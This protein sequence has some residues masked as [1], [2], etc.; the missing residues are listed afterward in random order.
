MNKR[1]AALFVA[2]MA[3]LAGCGGPSTPPIGPIKTTPVEEPAGGFKIAVPEGW[4][5]D[6][7]PMS[8][9]RRRWFAAR[10]KPANV[11][12]PVEALMVHVMAPGCPAA[13]VGSHFGG[14]EFASESDPKEFSIVGSAP[15]TV[16]THAAFRIEGKYKS[17]RYGDIFEASSYVETAEGSG[18]FVTS[19]GAAR[20]DAVVRA[21]LD[22]ALAGLE[23]VKRVVRA[24]AAQPRTGG[25]EIGFPEGFDE[26]FGA[27]AFGTAAYAIGPA[28]VQGRQETVS[29]LVAPPTSSGE[30][31]LAAMISDATKGYKQGDKRKLSIAG[32]PAEGVS[33][34]PPEKSPRYEMASAP[35]RLGDTHAMLL[36]HAAMVPPGRAL[37]ILSSTAATIKFKAVPAPELK[38]VRF[39]DGGNRETRAPEGWKTTADQPVFMAILDEA[40]KIPEG[41]GPPSRQAAVLEVTLDDDCNFNGSPLGAARAIAASF[42]ANK[43]TRTLSI[44]EFALPDGRQAARMVAASPVSYELFLFARAST[45]TLAQVH[46]S[47]LPGISGLGMKIGLEALAATRFVPIGD[48]AAP[49]ADVLERSRKELP[50]LIER[51]R[52]R[53]GGEAWYVE[54]S[55]G[56]EV[57]GQRITSGADGAWSDAEGRPSTG[58][59]VSSTMEGSKNAYVE[60]VRLRAPG[61]DGK[62]KPITNELTI[63]T[64][65]DS[66]DEK[67]ISISRQEGSAE[68]RK[69]RIAIPDLWLPPDISNSDVLVVALASS[70][71]GVYSF[72]AMHERFL[73]LKWREYR[74]KGEEDVEVPAGK[75]K[76]RRIEAGPT[77]VYWVADGKVVKAEIGDFARKLTTK[78][79]AEK[80]LKE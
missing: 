50:A 6:V 70:P 26:Y 33:W 17:A 60:R 13:E 37:E 62:G 71:E 25:F 46:V 76:A 77:T 48:L 54:E 64:R 34:T 18:L 1:A 80:Y 12:L 79:A 7:L 78:E 32:R 35:F 31:F 72:V 29:I 28:D 56:K 22:A 68:P 38:A 43:K 16:G 75:F 65:I 8:D 21:R 45:G 55:Q 42:G 52:K 53:A 49:A 15:G 11:A 47:S 73:I 51:G 59:S 57:G 24:A 63:E 10:W 20:D 39:S 41:A 74:V 27:S 66:S 67:W 5:R 4:D 58:A 36:V 2:T 14:A 23:P 40:L 30:Q 19:R 3:G 9:P 44:E 61:K 69:D